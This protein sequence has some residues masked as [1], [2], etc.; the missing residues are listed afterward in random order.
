MAQILRNP[1]IVGNPISKKEKFFGRNDI[2]RFI[3]DNLVQ[4]ATVLFLHGQRRIGKTSILAQVPNFLDDL[5]QFVFISLSLEGQNQG[6]LADILHHLAIG[7]VESPELSGKNVIIPTKLELEADSQVLINDFLHQISQSLGGKKIV[8]LMDEFDAV[9]DREEHTITNEF[10]RYLQLMVRQ[11]EGMIHLIPVIGRQLDSEKTLFNLFRQ[12]PFREIGLLDETNTK[13]LITKTAEGILEYEADAINFIFE[14]TNGQPYC[15]QLLC[16]VIF[17]KARDKQDEEIENW[18]I[19]TKEDVNQSIDEAITKGEN[20]L[21]WF[22]LGLPPSERVV[23]AAIA[24]TQE[25]SR[26]DHW[27][28]LEDFGVTITDELYEALKTLQRG[29][30]IEEK[31]PLE[32]SRE[33]PYSY[34]IMVELVR[35][36]FIKKKHL[37]EEIL[38]LEKLHSE[39]LPLYAEAEELRNKENFREAITLFEQVLQTNPNH[40]NALF[41]MA[42]A[43]L[44]D[45]QYNRSVELYTRVRKVDNL[46]ITFRES[47]VT[48][49]LG[50]GRDL[51]QQGNLQQAKVQFTTALE[52]EPDN[53][54]VQQRLLE[55][56]T[57]LE[58]EQTQ[59][60]IKLQHLR[61]PFFVGVPVPPENFVGRHTEIAMAFDQIWNRGHLS[62]WG[63]TGMGKSTFLQYLTSTE[64]WTEFGLD[65]NEAIIIYLN[66]ENIFPFTSDA[67]WREIL[68]LLK[69]QLSNENS[70]QTNIE[71]ILTIE[72][73]TSRHFRQI[74]QKIGKNNQFLLLLLDNYEAA[75]L[76]HENYTEADI[77]KFVS[78]IR[79]LSVHAQESQFLSTVVTSNKRLNEIG[80][81][82]NPNTSPWYN[83]YLFQSLKPFNDREISELLSQMPFDLKL[84]TEIREGIKEICGGYPVLLQNACYVIYNI[85]RSGK[86]LTVETFVENF[87]K[88][89]EHI[90][91]NWWASFNPI[92]QTLLMLIILF[93]LDGRLNQNRRYDLSGLDRIFTQNERALQ[94]L[95]YRGFI[96]RIES[97]LSDKIDYQFTSSMMEGWVLR[98]IESDT[99]ETISSREKIFLSLMSRK[100]MDNILT[101]IRW[102]WSN[103]DTS[104]L[105]VGWFSKIAKS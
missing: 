15:T 100:Q 5:K 23:F 22:R 4:G 60:S 105:T 52:L 93:R 34:V 31:E 28:L 83:H 41:S 3:E 74:L 67:F 99:E 36:W 33:Q 44:E 102:L 97:S 50:Y 8:L 88:A 10:F 101:A 43:C 12:A 80:P 94:N 78:E 16:S 2:F 54:R 29:S 14:L 72:N 56:E 96:K 66:C 20:G 103:T 89:T 37:S 68:I 39:I 71:Q 81:K 86:T 82:L 7:I 9:V 73:L 25:R 90:F 45:E 46:S 95:E 6:Y 47:L 85:W 61:N 63:S 59:I 42:A 57:Q 35:R 79:S 26:P 24:E 32:W 58:K 70:L 38:E 53:K 98:E 11:H 13:R 75:L 62:I 91:Q 84:P 69:E 87:S 19:I 21:A 64:V 1:Y 104:P 17:E 77:Q 30:F 49:L 40:F 76:P 27:K 92:E 48:S 55:V 18:Q 65:P 51:L